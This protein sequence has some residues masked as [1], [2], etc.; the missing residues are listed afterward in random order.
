MKK[1]GFTIVEL[2]ASITILAIIMTLGIVC[3]NIVSA[4]ILQSNYENKKS[5]IELKAAEYASDTGFLYTNV[6][7]LVKEG[8][9]SADDK[10]DN[11]VNPVTKES[12]NCFIVQIHNENDNLYGTLTEEEEC[13]NDNIL[14]TNMHL[15]INV[16]KES[17]FLE[18]MIYGQ[19][20]MLRSKCILKI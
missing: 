13:N 9:L 3:V 20:K 4:R 8:Y 1:N 16:I 14:Q 15:G 19:M 18:L 11:V 12:M 5:F 2:L 7:N 17:D 6:D 10:N